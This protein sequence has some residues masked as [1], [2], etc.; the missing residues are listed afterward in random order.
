MKLFFLIVMLFSDGQLV[1]QHVGVG[2]NEADCQATRDNIKA[3]A[4]AKDIDIWAECFE[5]KHQ[6]KKA[7]PPKPTTGSDS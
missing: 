2:T 6:P 3:R 5:V 4:A 1:E 7:A